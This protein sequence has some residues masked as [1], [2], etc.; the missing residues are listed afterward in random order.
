MDRIFEIIDKTGRKI[1]LTRK[2][3]NHIKQDHP[4]VESDV[5]I[6]EALE[7]PIK[8]TQ[9]YEGAKHYYYKHYKHRRCPDKYLLVI[10]NYLNGDAY[11][12]TAYYVR[13]TR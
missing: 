3:W 6:K 13:Y 4:E 8:I 10:V 7:K 5:V 12:I 9:P 1:R 2:Q 11:V